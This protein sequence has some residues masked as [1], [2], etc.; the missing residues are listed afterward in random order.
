MKKLIPLII[1]SFL[2]IPFQN[3]SAAENMGQRL[4]GR[5]LLAVNQG[6]AVY[7]VDDVNYQKHLIKWDNALPIFQ[8]FALGI[9]DED[10]IKI[11]V[12][13]ETIRENLDSDGDGYS[14]RSELAHGFSPYIPGDYKGAFKTDQNFANRL[15]NKFLLQVNQGGAI[16]Y[17]DNN[18]IRHNVRWDNLRWLFEGLALGIT[19]EDLG[20]IESSKSDS[21]DY[22]QLLLTESEVK[23]YFDFLEL[24]PE[25]SGDMTSDSDSSKF[26]NAYIKTF[27]NPDNID[28]NGST[29]DKIK[30]MENNSRFLSSLADGNYC[31]VS[32]EEAIKSFEDAR[33]SDV[34]GN[35]AESINNIGDGAYFFEIDENYFISFRV[36]NC[37][38]HIISV[39]LGEYL[40]ELIELAKLQSQKYENYSY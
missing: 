34:T 32:T 11:P 38:G 16:W 39:A 20:K 7:F 28:F 33:I 40:N 1:L 27:A 2:I 22:S 31:Y 8:Q 36:K 17:V 37:T 25:G 3:I 13:L 9:S 19:N 4:R 24:D 29:E 23:Q 21:F 26:I 15:R 18:G 30:Q 12:T 5:L 14:D 35:E 6:G 10:L